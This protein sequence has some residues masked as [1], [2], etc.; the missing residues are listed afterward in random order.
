M[1]FILKAKPLGNLVSAVCEISS[2]QKG[3]YE[4]KKKEREE[5]GEV[6]RG[7]VS[8]Y[9][10]DMIPMLEKNRM[11]ILILIQCVMEF[12]VTFIA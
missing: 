11:L 9:V 3:W 2:V 7:I 4:R 5:S 10:T 12:I 6:E 1:R 8:I